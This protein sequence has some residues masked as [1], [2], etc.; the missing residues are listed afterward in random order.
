M[1][2]NKLIHT[3]QCTIRMQQRLKKTV[4]RNKDWLRINEHSQSQQQR[5]IYS[6]PVFFRCFYVSCSLCLANFGA[7][8]ILFVGIMC[9][10]CCS[11]LFLL[12]CAFF[13]MHFYGISKVLDSCCC[14]VL[15]SVFAKISHKHSNC[16]NFK[17]QQT[18]YSL[19]IVIL[20]HSIWTMFNVK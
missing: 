15:L 2:L 3:A 12:L 10:V 5:R 9:T 18:I 14:V 16:F 7:Q 17:I 20:S 13:C 1:C 6:L 8:L 4:K 11:V 19:F